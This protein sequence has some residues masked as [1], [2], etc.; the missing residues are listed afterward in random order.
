M[1][2]D[3]LFQ[4][5]KHTESNGGEEVP[6]FLPVYTQ[7]ASLKHSCSALKSRDAQARKKTQ[8]DMLAES[9]PSN[10]FNTLPNSKHSLEARQ[11]QR[12]KKA[13]CF[14]ALTVCLDYGML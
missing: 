7:T 1:L 11:P 3:Q 2:G 10:D 13:L 9:A 4:K 14:K 6:Y 8:T 5:S 12:T